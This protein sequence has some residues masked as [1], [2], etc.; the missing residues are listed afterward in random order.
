MKDTLLSVDYI[1]SIS[2][3]D[4]VGLINQWNVL[5]GSHTTLSKWR[6]YSQLDSNSTLLEIACTTG[7]SSRELVLQSGCKGEGI[8]ISEKSVD[9]ANYNKEHYAPSANLS[10]KVADGY[11]FTSESKFSHIVVGAALGFFP[12]PKKMLDHCVSLLNDGG[13]VLASPFYVVE[14]IPKELVERAQSVFGITPTQVPYK[15][16]M[17]HYKDLE[18]IFEDRNELIQE[19]EDELIHYCTST[20]N[21][22]VDMLNVTD[23]SIKD[24]MCERLYSIKKMSN[25][26][27]PYQ[28]Y[29][30]LVLKYRSDV[31]PNR[32]VELF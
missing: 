25:D 2:Y 27:R 12:D 1:N 17:K 4:F 5:P 22:A 16:I 21:R 20:I 28:R 32:Y 7:F 29:S 18:V 11:T 26:L 19:T 6:I 31:Y 3:T 14:V 10:Y 13:Y 23:S 9:M 30:T 8:D 15:E 24:A